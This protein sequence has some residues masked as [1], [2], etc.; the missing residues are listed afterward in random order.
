MGHL[1]ALV[2]KY[3]QQLGPLFY[4]CL[5]K[6]EHKDK[7]SRVSTFSSKIP[8]KSKASEKLRTKFY[9]LFFYT[10]FKSKES[11]N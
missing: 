4:T 6:Q 9:G 11:V 8:F 10:C 1:C 2:P 3:N 7:I 5:A